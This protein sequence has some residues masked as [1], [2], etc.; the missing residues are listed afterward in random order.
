M[1]PA[2]SGTS[3]H[4]SLGMPLRSPFAGLNLILNIVFSRKEDKLF[5]KKGEVSPCLQPRFAGS[6]AT[7]SPKG[8]AL[9]NPGIKQ[10]YF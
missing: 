6:S 10:I 3:Q 9:K 5:S 8:S 1:R 2:F 4:C 7:P